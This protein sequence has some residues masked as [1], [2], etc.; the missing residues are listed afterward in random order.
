[1]SE[2]SVCECIAWQ[3]EGGLAALTGDRTAGFQPPLG[4]S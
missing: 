3:E 4:F 1:M 2:R